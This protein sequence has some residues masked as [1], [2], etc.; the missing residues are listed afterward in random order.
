MITSVM[1]QDVQ[2]LYHATKLATHLQDMHHV[3]VGKC[4][5]PEIKK[6]KIDSNREQFVFFMTF[7]FE[8]KKSY[9]ALSYTCYTRPNIIHSLL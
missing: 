3:S 7:F 8:V 5:L 4:A 2:S 1:L 9:D 6:K